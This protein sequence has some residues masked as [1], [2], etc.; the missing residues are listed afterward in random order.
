MNL[1][2]VS[3]S[4]FD[5]L[6]ASTNRL[7]D[8]VKILAQRQLDLHRRMDAFQNALESTIIEQ[9][10]LHNESWDARRFK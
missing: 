2:F 3:K 6:V 7:A 9:E 10:R 1:E 5:Y 8:C 4:D